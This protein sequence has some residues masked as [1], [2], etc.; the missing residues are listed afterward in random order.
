[1]IAASA[2]AQKTFDLKGASRFFDVKVKV[3]KCDS[4]FCDGKATFSFFK[5]GAAMPYQVIN[6]PEY[7]NLAR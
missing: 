2:F 6:V 4:G 7:P 5:K 1:M 3:A